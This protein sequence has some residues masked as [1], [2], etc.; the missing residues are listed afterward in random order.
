[1][2]IAK[3]GVVWPYK[4]P[5]AHE[6]METGEKNRS[7]EEVVMGRR[8]SVMITDGNKV[9]TG[10]R[11]FTCSAS[12]ETFWAASK[13]LNDEMMGSVVANIRVERFELRAYAG[14][15]GLNRVWFQKV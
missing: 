7:E 12:G 8:E 5:K 1:V 6:G 13:S 2:I 9:S 14:K 3:G 10:E 11:P 15:V 4:F